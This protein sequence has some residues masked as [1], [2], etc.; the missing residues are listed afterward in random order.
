MNDKDPYDL[1]CK[2]CGFHMTIVPGVSDEAK[3]ASDRAISL[4]HTPC[5]GKL[6]RQAP[7]TAYEACP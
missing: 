7:M 3:A 1:V 4:I 5:R 6:K 2:K